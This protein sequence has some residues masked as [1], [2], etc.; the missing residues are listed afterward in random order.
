MYI[1]LTVFGTFLPSLLLLR[2]FYKKDLHPEP[3]EV[4]IGTFLYGFFDHYSAYFHE[5]IPGLAGAP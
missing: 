4:L 3:T 5:W 1:L 2:Y